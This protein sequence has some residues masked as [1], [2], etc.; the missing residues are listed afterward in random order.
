ML[1]IKPLFFTALLSFTPLVAS[2]TDPKIPVTSPTLEQPKK[3]A[4]IVVISHP[5]FDESAPNAF[6][7][8]HWANYLHINTK[9][10][11]ILDLLSFGAHDE[12]DQDDLEEAQRLLRA[13][14]FLR[15]AKISFAHQDPN[16]DI[17][18][19]GEVV[20]V[21][22]WDNWSLLPTMS[23]GRSGGESTFS[24]GIKED[25]LLGLGI[26]TRIKYSSDDDRTGYKFAVKAPLK[27]IKHATLGFSFYDNSD[28]QSSQMRFVKPFYTLNGEHMYQS[29]FAHTKQVDTLR[30][31]G[32]DVNEFHHDIE[33]LN[34]AYGWRLHHDKQVTK[35]V[36]V[37]ATQDHHSFRHTG[38]FT[39]EPLPQDREFTY[40][41]VSYQH[42]E[43]DY[44]VLTNVNLINY[45]ED[46]NLGWQYQIK[47]GVETKDR[48]DDLGYHL[49]FDVT[50]GYKFANQLA[51]LSFDAKAT[52]GTTQADFYQAN[53]QAEYFY[54]INPRWTAYAKTRVS[55]SQ[56]NYLDRPFTLG[57]ETGV[58]GYPNDY[59][60][61][62]QQ[63][64][65]TAE[66][67]NYPNINLYQLAELG[68]AA[69][70]DIGHAYGGADAG[71]EESGV[72]GSIGIGA[73]LYSSR[74]SYGN[75]AHIDLT[76][77][78]TSGE[79]VNDWEWRFVVKRKF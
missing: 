28:G 1:S 21:E 15:D 33:Y 76:L 18:E 68:W 30:Q 55:S 56:N 5:I 72:L 4:R 24:V 32:R 8:H 77:P 34:F 47:V 67:R 27:W 19:D 2:A 9:E 48:H 59:Q 35:R 63:W 38:E 49:N 12:I 46:F 23:V 25:N 22:T 41:W 52:L 73:R 39:Q 37:G 70:I 29:S 74:S 20:I 7:L 50:K 69:F 10:S 57:D 79:E 64:L 3:V 62:D 14:P 66:V 31:N 13:E 51:L 75:V 42:I 6:F 54:K 44:H 17:K 16:A 61:G 53:L 43:D 11:T 40:P 71:N 60:Y 45:N 58:R 26:K 65:V 36:M 78:F